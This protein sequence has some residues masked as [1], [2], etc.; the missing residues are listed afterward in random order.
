M[1]KEI[2]NKQVFLFS[3]V[4][5]SLIAAPI[6]LYTVSIGGGFSH[7]NEDWGDFGS[8]IGGIYSVMFSAASLIAVLYSMQKTQKNHREQIKILNNEQ[9]INELQILLNQLKKSTENKVFIGYN[10]NPI[11]HKDLFGKCNSEIK[12][13]IRTNLKNKSSDRYMKTAMSYLTY[14]H[15]ANF[16]EEA[17]LAHAI[18]I[19]IDNA[20]PTLADAYKVIFENTIDNNWR[21]FI[22]AQLRRDD[23]ISIEML[24]NW[25]SFSQVPLEQFDCVA[26]HVPPNADEWE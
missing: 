17:K 14:Y 16:R 13:K 24:N 3:C 2:S 1:N 5:A 25:R 10:G 4:I 11:S 18:L 26:F 21:F 7:K 9:T 20:S 19:R 6:I 22:E 12:R 8:Y 15:P 23:K